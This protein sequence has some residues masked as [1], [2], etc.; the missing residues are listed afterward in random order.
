MCLSTY[1]NIELRYQK[2]AIDDEE[3]PARSEAKTSTNHSTKHELLISGNR[4]VSL[5]VSSNSENVHSFKSTFKQMPES[6]L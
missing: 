5:N 3:Q 4:C 1:V 2:A 6:T